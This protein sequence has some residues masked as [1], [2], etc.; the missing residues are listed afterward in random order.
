MRLR[1]YSLF[2]PHISVWWVMSRI[3]HCNYR[4]FVLQIIFMRVYMKKE[5]DETHQQS[6]QE[7]EHWLKIDATYDLYWILLCNKIRKQY[8]SNWLSESNVHNMN[9]FTIF[10]SNYKTLLIFFVL[11]SDNKLYSTRY[12]V[13][14][15]TVLMLFSVDRRPQFTSFI[16]Q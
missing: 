11:G 7:K 13:P 15:T 6:V 9:I 8:Q 2:Y 16:V 10:A 14:C 12:S 1:I 4:R 3:K 5:E